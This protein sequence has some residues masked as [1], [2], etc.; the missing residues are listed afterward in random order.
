MKHLHPVGLLLLSCTCL[1]LYPVEPVRVDIRRREAEALVNWKASLAGTDGSLASWSLANYTSPCSWTYITCD[2][3]KRI[4]EIHLNGASLNGT[5]DEFNFLAF[6]HLK[7]LILSWNGLHGTIPTG[8]GNLTSLVM[9]RIIGNPY[10][11]GAIPHSIGQLTQLTVLELREL[12]LNSM[13]P[14]EI[15]N[16]TR[17][18]VLDLSSATLTG[19]IPPITGML[20]KLLFLSLGNNN[21]TG[22]IPMEIGN[23]IAGIV[24]I[25]FSGNSLAEEIPNGVTT[26]LGLRYLNLSGNL[27]SGCIPKDIGNLV[28]LQSLDFSRNR[29]S[30]E[31]PPS[32][33]GLKSIGALNLSSNGLS[34]RIPMGNQLQT[35]AHPSIYSN[36]PGLCGFPLNDCVNSSTSIQNETTQAAEDMELLWFYCFVAAGFI[37]GFWLYWGTFLFCSETWRCAFYQ[38]VDNVQGKT[39]K[40]IYSCMSCFQASVPERHV[41][42]CAYTRPVSSRV[43]KINPVQGSQ[44]NACYY[45]PYRTIRL[46]YF[47]SS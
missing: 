10:L 42:R 20:T 11:R 19:S 47:S 34:G 38:Y 35:L 18:Q 21:L 24:G 4:S 40:K 3:G 13:L 27:L 8:I 22:S 17:L 6:P 33:V 12:G 32:F 46:S 43:G 44:A 5:L 31:I 29:L 37:F 16:L 39:T 2:S 45:L 14:E 7:N 1:L 15:G 25:D 41:E 23:M 30:G 9:L 28:W 26:L 36:N